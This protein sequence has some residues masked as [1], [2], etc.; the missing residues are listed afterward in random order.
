MYVLHLEALFSIASRARPNP[1]LPFLH[2]HLSVFRVQPCLKFSEAS[3]SLTLSTSISS[4][5]KL[6]LSLSTSSKA[7]QASS[8]TLN[9]SCVCVSQAL[10]S[11]VSGSQAQTL[12]QAHSLDG[13]R[14]KLRPF[15]VCMTWTPEETRYFFE[16]YAEERRKGN[17]AGI[18]MNKVGKANIMES[19][20]QRFKKNLP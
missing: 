8:L 9:I 17:K 2:E 20:E 18:S 11:F 12:S 1:S 10:P 19:F 4:S 16:L 15:L 7:L 13:E 6:R 5:P 3:S 14:Y